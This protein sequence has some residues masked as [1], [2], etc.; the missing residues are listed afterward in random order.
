MPSMNEVFISHSSSDDAFVRELQ[1]ALGDH[2]VNAWIDSREL[3]PGGLLDPDITKAIAE[4][5]AY[6]V[7]VSPASL[8]SKWVGK[9]LRHALAVQKERGREKFPIIPLSLD[10]TKLGVLE[11]FFE[12]EPIY[13]PVNSAAGGVETAMNEILVASG[14]K[15]AR[16][17]SGRAA[18]EGRAARGTRARTDRPEI[19]RAGGR[20]PRL[21][22]RATRL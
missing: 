2:G 8:Q 16:G 6:A 21:G 15:A 12:G 19:P 10:G 11:E 1:Q 14:Q 5:A 7:V 9:E 18:A 3:L 22:S 4:T 13:I 20:A 17:C